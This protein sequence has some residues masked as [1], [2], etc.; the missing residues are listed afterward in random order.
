MMVVM[1][2]K[3]LH[4]S[5]V[6]GRATP[7]PEAPV[8][9]GNGNDTTL[10]LTLLGT[11]LAIGALFA[12]FLFEDRKR[13]EAVK[14]LETR[15]DRL[16]M[17]NA[18][19]VQSVRDESARADRA[20]RD[21]LVQAEAIVRE[22]QEARSSSQQLRPDFTTFVSNQWRIF[23]RMAQ[24]RYEKSLICRSI[25]TD[26]IRSGDTVLL[27][28][29]STTDQVTAELVAK[30]VSNVSLYSNNVLAALHLTGTSSLR[31]YLLGGQFFERSWAVYSEESSRRIDQLG[32]TV[33]VLA[34]AAFR[35][36]DGIMFRNGEEGNQAFKKSALDC[37]RDHPETRLVLAIDSS[38]F[39]TSVNGHKSAL[40]KMAWTQLIQSSAARIDIVTS[41]IPK[42][43]TD[44][45]RAAIHRELD[46]CR[47]A[48]L[49]VHVA[50]L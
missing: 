14:H 6:T 48:G 3:W 28:S 12:I 46:K 4:T 16:E 31:Y 25:A 47:N 15:I 5:L 40:H 36:A 39:S 19:T 27:D 33:I 50:R 2:A 23:D 41:E 38:K 26:H 20:S 22:M 30:G 45:Q 43:V 44:A 18:N 24:Y 32:V 1:A 7:A 35:M 49:R 29:G 10:L 9:V 8:S 42:D 13:T 11:I 17:S 21:M 34:A 37:F